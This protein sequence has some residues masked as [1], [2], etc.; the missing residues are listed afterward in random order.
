MSNSLYWQCGIHFKKRNPHDNHNLE[1]KD[2]Q[3]VRSLEIDGLTPDATNYPF[4]RTLYYAYKKPATT[5]IKDF[6]G[7]AT[8]PTGQQV[9]TAVQQN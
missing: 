1:I 9:I 7:Y 2:Q 3:T 8:S 6:L 4:F 5:A